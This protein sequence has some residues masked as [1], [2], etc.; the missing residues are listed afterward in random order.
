MKLKIKFM[1]SD[2]IEI[3]FDGSTINDLKDQICEIRKVDKSNIRVIFAGK[4]LEDAKTLKSYNIIENCTIHS[5][6]KKTTSSSN[7]QSINN[8]STTVPLP[9]INNPNMVNTPPDINNLFNNMQMPNFVGGMP[10][11]QQMTEMFTNN[12]QMQ[13]MMNNMIQNPQMRTM[14]V[15]M[16]L[17]RMN[18]A[19]DSPM[20][21]IYEQMFS[22]MLSN[23][24]Q[25]INIMNMFSGANQNMTDP[26]NIQN[27]FNTMNIQPNNVHNSSNNSTTYS[28]VTETVNTPDPEPNDTAST[29]HASVPDIPYTPDPEPNDITVST[30]SPITESSLTPTGMSTDDLKEKYSEQ[31]CQI[32]NMGF[33]DESKI[34]EVL[35][36]SCGSVSIAL[37]K[38]LN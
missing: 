16:T 23:P 11:S 30:H 26:T 38:L 13:Q 37:N 36:Q 22:N 2:S 6:I 8:T 27:I 21:S 31:I 33:E 4:I 24:E 17:Q 9:D 15:N 18:L 10:T 29:T 25:F 19:L 32:K 1:T 35:E 7:S 14:L 20:R 5:L 28:P 12:P 3:N 34:I